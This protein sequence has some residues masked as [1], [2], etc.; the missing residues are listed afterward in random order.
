MIF[1]ADS[2]TITWCSPWRLGVRNTSPT[3]MI[4]H[5][6]GVYFFITRNSG[7]LP[8]SLLRKSLTYTTSNVYSGSGYR[9]HSFSN[10]MA[11]FIRHK[12]PSMTPF[13]VQ[14]YFSMAADPVIR[15]IMSWCSEDCAKENC[16]R[17]RR[18]K[19]FFLSEKTFHRFTIF[20]TLLRCVAWF[21]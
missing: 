15:L 2:F 17:A 19:F 14:Q 16:R 4:Q 3:I 6:N 20:S 9:Q 5:E 21:Y 12:G 18:K 7:S 10:K 13:L 1:L 8:K 11:V